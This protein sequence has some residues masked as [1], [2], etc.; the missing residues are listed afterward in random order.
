MT[1]EVQIQLIDSGRETQSSQESYAWLM[2]HFHPNGLVCPRCGSE[3]KQARL[4][5]KRQVTGVDDY[6]CRKCTKTFNV[7]SGTV[8]E[9][10]RLTPEQATLIL[11]GIV[12]GER[13]QHLAREVGVCRQTIQ[14]IRHQM[15]TKVRATQ[16]GD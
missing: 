2:E 3:L 1:T 4:F 14:A 10:R 15:E 11:Q 13:A 7:Y 6:R 5:R 8:F 12:R 9:G 16:S